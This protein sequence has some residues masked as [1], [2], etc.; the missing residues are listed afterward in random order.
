LTI[1]SHL[2]ARGDLCGYPLP[3]DWERWLDWDHR[4]FSDF[5]VILFGDEQTRM[6]RSRDLLTAVINFNFGLTDN[7]R[8]GDIRNTH[9]EQRVLFELSQLI[10]NDFNPEHKTEA[11]KLELVRL[12]HR[13][14]KHDSVIMLAMNKIRPAAINP[15]EFFKEFIVVRSAHWV[16]WHSANDLGIIK[17]YSKLSSS[18]RSFSLRDTDSSQSA[19]QQK[20]EKREDNYRKNLST[21]DS[22][23]LSAL[24]RIILIA[25]ERMFLSCRV[26]LER[27]MLLSSLTSLI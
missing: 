1:Q 16:I 19:S 14:L 24:E 9:S 17:P 10:E 18:S 23:W 22:C 26:L 5:M 7:S 25:I 13:N 27:D 6:D 20:R 11:G 15:T 21:K 3:T 4:K 8:L 2:S 12:I